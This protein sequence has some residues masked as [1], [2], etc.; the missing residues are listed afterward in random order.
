MSIG[1]P[2]RGPRRW[3]G[4]PGKHKDDGNE[5]GHLDGGVQASAPRQ[6]HRE[7]AGPRPASPPDTGR[8]TQCPRCPAPWPAGPSRPGS[9]G[10]SARGC[11]NHPHEHEGEKRQIQQ[12]VGDKR[13]ADAA[14]VERRRGHAQVRKTERQG[15]QHQRQHQHQ[16]DE[17]LPMS[18][19]RRCARTRHG[20][21]SPSCRYA[22]RRMRL[23]PI[24]RAAL[25]RPNA[26]S[27]AR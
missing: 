13:R 15:H 17:Q 22:A 21:V 20:G 4:G 23:F 26:R 27:M 3:H 9:L 10:S 19:P 8:P 16:V 7:A 6:V 12:T 2:A 24:Q 5:D 1:T 18:A 11:R 25:G 14:H